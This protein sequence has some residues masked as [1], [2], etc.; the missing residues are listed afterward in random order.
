MEAASL[1][2]R[3]HSV[4]TLTELI[5]TLQSVTEEQAAPAPAVQAGVSRRKGRE[6]LQE[7]QDLLVLRVCRATLV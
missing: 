4:Q 1:S 5:V 7:Y 3:S 6:E 2:P